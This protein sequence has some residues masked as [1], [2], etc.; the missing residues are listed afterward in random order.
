MATKKAATEKLS[1]SDLKAALNKHF[2]EGTIK[3]GSDPDIAV[4]RCP[5]GVLSV[6]EITRGGLPF[7]RTVEIYGPPSAG[8]TAFCYHVM[9]QAQMMGREAAYI[10]CEK[11]FSPKFAEHIGV[12]IERLQ[13]HEQVHGPRVIDVVEAMI[14]SRLFGVI[15]VD[16]TSA[17]LPIEDLETDME[18]SS[19]GM[20]QAK[21][22]SKALRKLT[23]ANINGSEGTLVVF[24]NQI[25]DAIGV[26]YGKK[27]TTSGGRAMGFYAS[28]RLEFSFQETI[29]GK[30]LNVNP[31]TGEVKS[32]DTKGIVGHR[33]GVTIDK[34][35]TGLRPKEKTTC[36]FD[37][38]LGDFDPVEDL[39]YVGIMYRLIERSGNSWWVVGYE[40]DKK[41]HRKAFKKWLRKSHDVQ[42]ELELKIRG[43]FPSDE[44]WDQ[45]I[46][47]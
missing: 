6:D 40:K 10:D 41:V 29:K 30:G 45:D 16:S 14:R 13:I 15:V 31:T 44:S 7:G 24:L 23:A 18:K 11:T 12:D 39:I 5:T 38:R 4:S 35:K 21:L 2:G 17:L 47:D 8:K 34:D 26:T 22:M 3:S 33:L 42:E 27:T 37:Y 46:D 32:E 9:A 36:V 43:S 19:Y 25:R 20:Q 1:A 28:T